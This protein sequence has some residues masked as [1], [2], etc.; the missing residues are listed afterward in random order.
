MVAEDNMDMGKVTKV[1]YRRASLHGN[2]H[3]GYCKP[4]CGCIPP[5]GA[6]TV[7]G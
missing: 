6:L 4:H 7:V 2:V 5:Y 1:P 3:G